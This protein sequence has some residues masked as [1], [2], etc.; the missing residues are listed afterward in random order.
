MRTTYHTYKKYLQFLLETN[1]SK[2]CSF[3]K[4]SIPWVDCMR[5]GSKTK[6]LL[7]SI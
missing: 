4:A 2:M 1:I 3:L 5:Q 6:K 7:K